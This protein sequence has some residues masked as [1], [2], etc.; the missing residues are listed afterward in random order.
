MSYYVRSCHV[1]LCCVSQNLSSLYVSFFFFD[2][3]FLFFFQINIC[4]VIFFFIGCVYRHVITLHVVFSKQQLF[5]MSV[6]FHWVFFIVLSCYVSQNN[7]CLSCQFFSSSIF[8]VTSCHVG[9]LKT[10]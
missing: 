1:R 8:I 9:F 4:H 2:L 5:V 6:F 3:F 10:T 7:S